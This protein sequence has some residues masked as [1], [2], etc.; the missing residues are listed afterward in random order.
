MTYRRR[1][2][3]RLDDRQSRWTSRERESGDGQW[4]AFAAGPLM[5]FA[6]A[7]AGKA[8]APCEIPGQDR[9]VRTQPLG[10]AS[11]WAVF[12]AG[13]VLGLAA[14]AAYHNSFSG[15]FIWDD[16]FSITGHPTIRHWSSALSPPSD[17]GVGGRPIS[18][19]TLALNYAWGGT[20]VWGYH[21]L[22]LLIH[23]LAGLTL[24]GLGA[25]NTAATGP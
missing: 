7:M 12:L 4:P 14:F 24:L 22:N 3:I 6:F 20:D 19:L 13:T 5:A 18:N 8:P 23:T 10:S 2:R 11:R 25:A 9:I 1:R 15:P 21:A 17:V 16:L